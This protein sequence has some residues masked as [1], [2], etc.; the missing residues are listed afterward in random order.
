MLATLC[1]AW[2]GGLPL[3]V[4]YWGLGVAGNM[5]FVAA[6]VA[7]VLIAGLDA[8][9]LLWALYLLSLAWFVFVFVAIW[10]AAAAWRGSRVWAALARLG[11]SLGI[12]RMATELILLAL[13][14]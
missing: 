1:K 13:V 9:P 6:L 3:P 4:V 14:S 5:G 8:L 10:R 12:V 2:Q 11:V 7:A